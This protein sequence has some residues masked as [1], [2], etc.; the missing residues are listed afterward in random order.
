MAAWPRVAVLQYSPQEDPAVLNHYPTTA[1]ET[2]QVPMSYPDVF[3]YL[4]RERSTFKLGGLEVKTAQINTY[5]GKTRMACNTEAKM[6]ALCDRV[7]AD[8]DGGGVGTY[9][10]DERVPPGRRVR[11]IIYS[12]YID[13]GVDRVA[14]ALGKRKRAGGA[15]LLTGVITGGTPVDERADTVDRYNSGGLDVVVLSDC[16]SQ[17]VTFLG[18]TSLSILEPHLNAFAES[19]TVARAVRY[20]SH[21]LEARPSKTAKT[22]ADGADAPPSTGEGGAIAALLA[23]LAVQQGGKTH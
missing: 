6:A 2:V 11:Q 18:T 4:T 19:Q 10:P 15:P 1:A 16:A 23:T 17:G 20:N 14:R 7:V 8:A 12:H 3:T 22:S 5:R 13:E 9:A 21:L